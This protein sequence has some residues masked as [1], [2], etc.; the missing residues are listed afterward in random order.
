MMEQALA[1]L[2]ILGMIIHFILY[3]GIYGSIDKFNCKAANAKSQTK[4]ERSIGNKI[5]IIHSNIQLR[6][7]KAL[8]HFRLK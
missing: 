8:S 6:T 5:I 2:I 4:T 3:T 1:Y 7:R